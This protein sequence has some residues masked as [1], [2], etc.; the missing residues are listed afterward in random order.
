V[1]LFWEGVTYLLCPPTALNRA[2]RG[3]YAIRAL[4][5]LCLGIKSE[6][7]EGVMHDAPSWTPLEK[8]R[9]VRGFF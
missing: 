9:Q 7:L 5:E 4:S 6:R 8:P 2:G 3:A 1:S